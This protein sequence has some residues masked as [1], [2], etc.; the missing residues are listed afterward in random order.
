M[1]YAGKQFTKEVALQCAVPAR[2]KR[3]TYRPFLDCL[4]TLQSSGAQR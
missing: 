3:D 1:E 2:M 4:A